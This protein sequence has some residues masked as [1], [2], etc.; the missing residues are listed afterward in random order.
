MSRSDQF[1]SAIG[2]A[3]KLKTFRSTKTEMRETIFV[4]VISSHLAAKHRAFVK[5]SW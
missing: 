3:E 5:V 2:T 1:T 4:S